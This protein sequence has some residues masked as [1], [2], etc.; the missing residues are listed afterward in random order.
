MTSSKIRSVPCF[1]VMARSP[2][3]YP[4]AGATRPMLPHTGSMITAAIS[5]AATS[6]ST[7][8]RSLNGTTN[9]SRAAPSGTPA[10]PGMPSV[11]APE[12]AATSKQSA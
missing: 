4:G 9:V 1:A 2:S 11:A 12:P 7:A 5:P 8:A 10:E 3:R 6:F